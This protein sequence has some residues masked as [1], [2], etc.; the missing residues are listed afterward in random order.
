MEKRNSRNQLAAGPRPAVAE[1]PPTVSPARPRCPPRARRA[2]VALRS[3]ERRCYVGSG[4]SRSPPT[5]R[6]FPSLFPECPSPPP[7][8][9]VFLCVLGWPNLLE[10][11]PSCGPFSSSPTWI[12]VALSNER[13][14]EV[15]L[16]PQKRKSEIDAC[17]FFSS[18]ENL[19]VFHHGVISDLTICHMI[20]SRYF[21]I[22]GVFFIGSGDRHS[23]RI[24]FTSINNWS[25][26]WI[27]SF[28][29]WLLQFLKRLIGWMNALFLY[30][31]LVVY[32]F[33]PI[34]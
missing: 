2:P 21:K 13:S 30:R 14:F 31:M 19:P 9:R 16:S 5:K 29:P 26:V 32:S 17:F 33:R 4:S 10:I 12:P 20:R 6:P 8:P 28:P 1:A 18:C 25:F 7:P 27:E 3:G 22:V 11:G 24:V 15:Q 23:S 34:I